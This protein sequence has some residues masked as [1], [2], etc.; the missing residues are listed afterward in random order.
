[1]LHDPT[2]RNP[3]E[4]PNPVHPVAPSHIAGTTP[5]E[6]DPS[7][8]LTVIVSSTRP[9]RFADVVT[10]WFVEHARTWHDGPVDVIDLRDF[11][12][13]APAALAARIDAADAFVFVVPEYNRSFPAPLKAAIDSVGVQWR[14]KPAAIVSYG[15]AS[16]GL[17]AAEQLNAVLGGLH[18]VS[19]P[20]GVSFHH[21]WERFDDDGRPHEPERVGRA[22]ERMLVVL[23]WWARALREARHRAPYPG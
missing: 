18:V 5:F 20:N 12:P 7:I 16:G 8:R 13:A 19:V 1:M 10:T 3:L 9:R 15:G 22:A 17:R 21:A 4:E 14:G 11:D 23:D 2:A 6:Q